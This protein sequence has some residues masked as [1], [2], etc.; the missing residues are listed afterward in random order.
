MSIFSKIGDVFKKAAPKVLG[1]V[2]GAV[3]TIVAPGVGTAIGGA[4]G[5]AVGGAIAGKKPS[6]GMPSPVVISSVPAMPTGVGGTLGLS[7]PRT[8]G[9]GIISKG[10]SGSDIPPTATVKPAVFDNVTNTGLNPLWLLAALVAFLW[11]GR[12][13]RS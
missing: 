3:G 8:I 5:S 9:G 6:T 2:G 10:A 7:L 12:F 13:R 1:V 4:L 11:F